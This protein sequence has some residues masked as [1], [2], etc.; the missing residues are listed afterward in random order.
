M[1][2]KKRNLLS[3]SYCERTRLCQQDKEAQLTE[4]AWMGWHKHASD[5]NQQLIK[6]SKHDVSA[7]A[8][9]SESVN[10]TRNLN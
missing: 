4:K 2:N 5:C 8:Q 1:K 3:R 10:S 9:D 6:M 7:Q